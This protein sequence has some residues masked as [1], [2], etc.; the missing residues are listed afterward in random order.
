MND[1]SEVRKDVFAWFGSTAYAAQ[2]F[3]VELCILLLLVRRLNEPSITPEELEIVDTK[4]SR[5]T[6]G[7]LLR[8]LKKHLVI[9]PDFQKMLDGYLDKRN[10]LMHYF[11]FDHA[12]DLLAPDGCKKMIEQLKDHYASLKEADAIAQSMSRNM[13]KHLG[14]SEEEVQALTEANIRNFLND[15]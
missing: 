7:T 11:F 8:E 3:E 15:E 9:H 14:I 4:L 5:G 10:F 1:E 12:G 6:L 2:C 13:R